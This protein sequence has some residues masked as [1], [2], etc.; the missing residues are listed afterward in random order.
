MRPLIKVRNKVVKLAV[1]D[2]F[3]DKRAFDAKPAILKNLALNMDK[4]REELMSGLSPWSAKTVSVW[5]RHM[6][7]ENLQTDVK[8][9]LELANLV[10]IA[11][12]KAIMAKK[13][14]KKRAA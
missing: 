12:I 9:L 5:V 4:I 11:L 8:T 2:L 1:D 14:R 13:P 6:E 10:H 3:E 7:S